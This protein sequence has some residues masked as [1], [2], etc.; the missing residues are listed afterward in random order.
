MA[1]NAAMTSDLGAG[2]VFTVWLAPELPER[3]KKPAVRYGGFGKDSVRSRKPPA[4]RD[5]LGRDNGPQNSV[6]AHGIQR[7]LLIS[8]GHVREHSS[9]IV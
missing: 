5:A 3:R 8:H 4:R 7:V 2:V 1:A 9:A 6:A